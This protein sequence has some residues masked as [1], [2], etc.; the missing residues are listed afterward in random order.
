MGTRVRAARLE[1]LPAVVA[2]LAEQ[3]EAPVEE[4]HLRGFEAIEADERN[5]LLVLE[6]DG[7][8]VGCLQITVIPGLGH[9]GPERA[10]L[11]GIRVREDRRG[12]GLGRTLV[13]HAIERARARGC[14]LAQLTSNKRRSDAHRFYASLGFAASHEGFRLGL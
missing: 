9:A 3:D 7:D 12:A 11:E 14:S 1:D 4:R 10:L 8:V 5:E 2:L 6:D 13:E